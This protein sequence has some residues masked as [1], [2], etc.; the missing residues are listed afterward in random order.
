MKILTAPWPPA[1]VGHGVQPVSVS[2]W[3]PGKGVVVQT[4]WYC[5]G[6]VTPP[7]TTLVTT[8]TP[9]GATLATTGT[10]LGP[11]PGQTPVHYWV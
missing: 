3:Y 5:G 6:T 9:P 7:G 1:D 8:G 11:T 4:S 10:L 2:W